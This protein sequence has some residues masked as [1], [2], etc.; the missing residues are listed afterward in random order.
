M[1][2]VLTNQRNYLM[3]NAAN[4]MAATPRVEEALKFTSETKAQNALKNLPK[5]LSRLGYVVAPYEDTV[6]EPQDIEVENMSITAPTSVQWDIDSVIET[7]SAFEELV[8][9]LRNSKEYLTAKQ[10]IA[11]Q[12]ILDLEHAIEFY[13]YNACDG[14]KMYK[15][16]KEQRIER[17]KAKDLLLLL[18]IL[19]ESVSPEFFNTPP[20]KRI[21]G[22]KHRKY[23]PRVNMDIFDK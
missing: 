1:Y 4:A 18:Q 2:Y 3:L 10:T 20:S 12:E 11:E 22:L 21:E 6:D 15:A 7:V 23:K 8:D 13:N 19:E 17:R 14:Y 16:I 9:H 5:T